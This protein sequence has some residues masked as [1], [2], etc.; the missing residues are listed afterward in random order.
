MIS[1]GLNLLLL[2]AICIASSVVAT[3]V[4]EAKG[5]DSANWSLAALFFGPIALIGLAGMPDRRLR[6]YMRS[7]AIKLEAL[8]EKETVKLETMPINTPAPV[9]P[10]SYFYVDQMITDKQQIV[11]AVFEQFT[12]E[13][14]SIA[15]TQESDELA[16]WALFVKVI[17]KLSFAL[18]TL[19]E[20]MANMFGRGPGGD[21]ST[22]VDG[23]DLPTAN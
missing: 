3:K 20:R 12:E 7:I 17:A 23:I 13:E 18:A 8:E 2:I 14:R 19:A 9:D 21:S 22:T 6:H 5:L 15:S 16:K 1:A 4:A 11:A 10:Q